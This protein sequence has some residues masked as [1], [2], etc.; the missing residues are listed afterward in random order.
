LQIEKDHVRFITE[1]LFQARISRLRLVKLKP[2]G[3]ENPT[4]N[5]LDHR[6]VFYEKDF[7]FHVW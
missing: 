7:L 4:I 2:T 5:F 3:L 6:V 1:D